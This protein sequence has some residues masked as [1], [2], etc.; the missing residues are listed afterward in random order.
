MPTGGCGSLGPC[1]ESSTPIQTAIDYLNGTD[2]NSP[3]YLTGGA[4]PDDGTI[5]VEAGTYTEDV[6]IDG[7]HWNGGA[8]TPA[9]LTL[10]GASSGTTIL[11]GSVFIANMNIFTLSGFTV[12]DADHSENPT[13]IVAVANTG[14]LTLSDECDE[15]WGRW[16][17][18]FHA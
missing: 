13:G 12:V 3:W 4:T 5:Y 8:N 17:R 15:Q 7:L 2:A 1:V 10:S 18:Y 6:I 14:T 16:D 9:A 11:D